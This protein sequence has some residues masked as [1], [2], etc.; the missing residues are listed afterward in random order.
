MF[1][2]TINTIL[3]F[4]N[5]AVMIKNHKDPLQRLQLSLFVFVLGAILYYSITMLAAVGIFPIQLSTATTSSNTT[6]DEV[7]FLNNKGISL[8]SLGK[9]NESVTYFDKVLAM[10][11]NNIIA[12]TQ[13]ANAFGGLGKY[14]DAIT[15][16]DRVL[17]ID[18]KNAEALDDKGVSFYHLGNY[19]KAISFYDKALAID[20]NHTFALYDKANALEAL[21]NFTQSLAYFDKAL[22]IDPKNV[23]ALTGKK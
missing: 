13:K 10:D 18:P 17:A 21:G 11:P 5:T 4:L 19:I 16:Y 3:S 1:T 12:L 9:F 23:D 8:N 6:L 20:P 2:K 22:A 14:P 15:Y 7:N